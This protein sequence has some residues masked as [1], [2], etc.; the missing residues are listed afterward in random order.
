MVSFVPA[1]TLGR[2]NAAG[3][4]SELD[5][6]NGLCYHARSR[7]GDLVTLEELLYDR[8]IDEVRVYPDE[9]LLGAESV[10]L[11]F[12]DGSDL[13]ISGAG[14]CISFGGSIV[15]GVL[16]REMNERS[17]I[18]KELLLERIAKEQKENPGVT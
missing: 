5:F 13:T 10:K 4:F 8:K 3:G 1:I 16:A 12:T 15:V 2:L 9:S 7:L 17:A 11:I 6:A 18:N 14:D